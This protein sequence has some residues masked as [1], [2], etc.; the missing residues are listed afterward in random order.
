MPTPKQIPITLPTDEYIHEHNGIQL[1][2]RNQGPSDLKRKRVGVGQGE[3]ERDGNGLKCLWM[4]RSALATCIS[5][6]A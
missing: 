3:D 6:I 5:F 4:I 2:R 1:G